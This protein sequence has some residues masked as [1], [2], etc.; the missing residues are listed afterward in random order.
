MS[1]QPEVGRHYWIRYAKRRYAVW[2]NAYTL[3]PD[4]WAIGLRAER[5]GEEWS[6]IPKT[7][8]WFTTK[9][10]DFITDDQVLF[11]EGPLPEPSARYGGI[12]QT[13]LDAG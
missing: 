13:A 10:N 7:L 1:E 3:A 6:R 5:G 12:E 2:G 9:H 8:G 4:E 11:W